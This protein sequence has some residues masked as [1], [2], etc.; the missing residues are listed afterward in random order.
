MQP[1]TITLAVDT[2]NTGTTTDQE[3]NRYEEKINSSTY[4]GPGHSL[5]NRNLLQLYRTPPKRNGN[6]PGAAKASAK[7]TIDRQVSGVDTATTLVAPQILEISI[8]SPVGVSSADHLE[9]RQHGV[10]LLD[11]DTIVSALYELL[12]V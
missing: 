5:G 8:S 9:F 4:I 10:A 11:Y 6:F 2:A 12:S 3:Y 7:F 1:N